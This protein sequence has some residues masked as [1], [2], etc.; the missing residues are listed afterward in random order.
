MSEANRSV[1]PGRG[2]PRAGLLH[3]LNWLSGG[4]LLTMMVLMT[5]DVMGR[6][7]LGRPLVGALELIEL[8]LV[9]SVFAA[10]PMASWREDHIVADLFDP[11]LSPLLKRIL[12]AF[13]CLLAAIVFA[14]VLPTLWKLAKRSESFGDT[15]PQLGLPLSWVIFVICALCAITSL[16]FLVRAVV[17]LRGAPEKN[18]V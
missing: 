4:A 7:L 17:V 5:L 14:I 10:L 3:A 2:K 11:I 6:E 18:W 9:V 1:R 15:T 8:T 13:G 12:R 16:T